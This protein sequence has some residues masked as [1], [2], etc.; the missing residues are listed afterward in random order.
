MLLIPNPVDV[1]IDV[2]EHGETVEKVKGK[3]KVSPG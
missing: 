3:S 2:L 1:S